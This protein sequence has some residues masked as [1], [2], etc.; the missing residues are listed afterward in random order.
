MGALGVELVV[1]A[2]LTAAPPTRILFIGNS[3]TYFNNLPEILAS[4]GSV[5][6]EL[7]ARGG[8]T[9]QD[10]W[11]EGTAL[12]RIRSRPWDYVV[13]QEQSMLGRA[14]VDGQLAINDPAGFHRVV[15][16]FDRE[17]RAAGARTVLY[18]TW[19]GRTA[20][21]DHQESLVAAYRGI[22]RELGALVA[23]VGPAWRQARRERPAID[24]YHPD[25]RHPGPAGS[26][27][28]ALV[29]WE[30]MFPDLLASPPT[31]VRG[32]LYRAE[33]GT[34]TDS[35][36]GLVSLS[37][38]EMGFLASVARRAVRSPEVG[39]L[40]RSGAPA[41]RRLPAGRMIDSAALVGRWT[42]EILLY[43]PEP[44]SLELVVR[45]VEGSWSA[46]WTVTFRNGPIRNR[47]EINGLQIRDSVLVFQV[48]DPRWVGPI[49]RHR[50]VLTDEGLLG[51]VEVGSTMTPPHLRG[52]WKLRRQ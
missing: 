28:A 47:Y 4:F 11:S 35:I 37:A 12:D 19:A 10:H 16:L 31:Q 13:L 8:A 52:R 26:Y 18:L 9:L 15:R 21:D 48:D 14:Q 41:A 24:L 20:P 33:D 17:I 25:G 30:T 27:L 7:V 44:S 2:L 32:R 43:H 29:L 36:G 34:P 45:R 5:E 3:Y 46:E 1:A 42:G 38:D 23:P 40:S 39:P 49:E 50:A 51:L 22:G 6:T